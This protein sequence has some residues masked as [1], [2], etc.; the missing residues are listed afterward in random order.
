[1]S[2]ITSCQDKAASATQLPLPPK[3]MLNTQ[4]GPD[5]LQRLDIYLPEGRSTATTTS[6]ILIH[7]GGWNGGSKSDF[8]SYI[9]SFKKRLPNFAFFNLDYRLVSGAHLFPTQEQDIKKAIEFISVNAEAYGINKSSFVLLGASA[10][11]HLALLQAYKYKEPQV[12]A[13]ID[14]FG[15]T[16]LLAMYQKPWHPLVTYALQM[17]TGATPQSNKAIYIESSPLQYVTAQ[18]APTLIFHGGK[19]NVVDVSQSRLLE[20]KLKALGVPHEVIV[21]PHERHGWQGATLSRSFD[22]IEAF[23]EANLK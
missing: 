2:L 22:T 8:T 14:F 6:L 5:S 13:V 3:T 10:G 20:D 16:D 18:S 11:A 21:Y 17:I 9:D 1:M 12:K 4:Y 15:P 19:D 7:G 23:L